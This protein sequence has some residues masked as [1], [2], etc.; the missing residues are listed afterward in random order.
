MRFHILGP[1]EVIR[2]G[3]PVALGGYKQRAT[4]AMLVLNLNRVVP[5]SKLLESL[6]GSEVPATG[7]KMLQN[8]ASELRSMLTTGAGPADSPALLTHA[9][10]YLLHADPES[11]D[12]VRFSRLAEQG[13]AFAASSQWERA[14]HD[15]REA[16]AAWRGPV[17]ADLFE[18]RALW[19]DAVA[20][21]NTRLDVLE[22]LFDVELA[23]GRH[24]EI[25]AELEPLVEQEPSRERLAAQLM[26]TLY[27]C[28]RQLDA[29][30]VYRRTRD[31][32]IDRHGLEP[33]RELQELERSIL[34]HDAGLDRRPETAVVAVPGRP[35]DTAPCPEPTEPVPAAA[36]WQSV[37]M[38]A[39]L[40]D[41][42]QPPGGDD[43]R[44]AA[45]VGELSGL[46]HG[47]V[48]RHDGR[49]ISSVAGMT[50]IVFDG[51]GD[52]AQRAVR[53]GLA[54][55]DALAAR[56]DLPSVHAAAICA[57]AIVSYEPG[58]GNPRGLNGDAVSR[59]LRL[60][61]SAPAGV[62]RVGPETR[63]VTEADIRYT[64]ADE[65]WDAIELRPVR[66]APV[67]ITLSLC[68]DSQIQE[69]CG[70]LTSMGGRRAAWLAD[71]LDQHDTT[72][73]GVVVELAV[74]VVPRNVD[75][76]PEW[77]LREG[78]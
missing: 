75:E 31:S 48:A 8:A 10:G 70:L 64:P 24:R 2:D 43:A 4:L 49:V 30:G 52:A 13:R 1:L 46:V 18:S 58:D 11:V 56:P 67:Q 23:C 72:R 74:N 25:V 19:P 3:E 35:R 44:T 53:T 60:A 15:L 76:M 40:A 47:E 66:P 39:V 51:T 42:S 57:D 38:L 28:G 55:R 32:L 63:R 7:R 45:V 50:W 6:W 68:Q 69:L 22:D 65:G 33:S 37:S 34:N 41:L 5:A 26:L 14:R 29:L 21:Q 27:R 62:V 59:C 54:I 77:A 17:L 36:G 20:V 16:L 78:A 9:P 61:M 71:L 73:S 12:A